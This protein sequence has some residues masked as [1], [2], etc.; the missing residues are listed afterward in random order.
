MPVLPVYGRCQKA[1]SDASKWHTDEVGEPIT[2]NETKL[3]ILI[4][5]CPRFRK[6]KRAYVHAELECVCELIAELQKGGSPS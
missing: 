1:P 4:S 5:S 2:H 6:F 3:T